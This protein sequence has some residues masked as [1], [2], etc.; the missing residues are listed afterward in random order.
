MTIYVPLNCLINKQLEWPTVDMM[1]VS[2][3]SEEFYFWSI[4]DLLGS[5]LP[6]QE[7]LVLQNHKHECNVDLHNRCILQATFP[8]LNLYTSKL[9]MIK[10]TPVSKCKPIATN[11]C[12]LTWPK[13]DPNKIHTFQAFTTKSWSSLHR[14]RIKGKNTTMLHI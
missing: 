14:F 9:G 1:L 4:G 5:F 11:M 13:H 8:F 3:Q 2:K 12:Q 10:L 6:I 7:I